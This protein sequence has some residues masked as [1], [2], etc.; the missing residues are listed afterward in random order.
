MEKR[1]LFE[2][3]KCNTRFY[4]GKSGVEVKYKVLFKVK[5]DGRSIFVTYYDC[6]KCNKRHYVQVDDIKSNQ[7]QEKVSLM[8]RS[9]SKKRLD[10][11]DISKKQNE[12]FKKLN[13][14]L[15]DYRF[16]LKK[17]LNNQI[18]VSDNGKEFEVYFSV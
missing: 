12:K 13:K 10:Y 7:M 5:E 4:L 2:C 14:K 16:N 9:L 8:F 15:E 6:P 1:Y 18:I 3:E 17:E 11:K